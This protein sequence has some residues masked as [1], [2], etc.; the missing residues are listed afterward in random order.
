MTEII[1]YIEYFMLL[2]VNERKEKELS[3]DSV[4]FMT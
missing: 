4:N 1:K 3:I 2:S